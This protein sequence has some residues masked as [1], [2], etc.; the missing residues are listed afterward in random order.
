[1]SVRVNTKISE[2]SND[3][4]DKKSVEM[5]VS[6]SALINIAIEQYRTQTEVIDVL[7]QIMAELEKQGIKL[8]NLIT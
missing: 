2:R 1:M 3:W 6:K 8:T 5:A 4:L 7:P